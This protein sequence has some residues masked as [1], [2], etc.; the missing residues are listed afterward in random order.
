MV[1]GT[2]KR[3][4]Q[5]LLQIGEEKSP[6][7]LDVLADVCPNRERLERNALP[8]PQST[9]PAEKKESIAW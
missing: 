6:G 7:Y 2:N 3:K 8:S 4:G 9:R 5:E 1:S